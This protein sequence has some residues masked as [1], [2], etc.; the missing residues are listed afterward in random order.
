MS[1]ALAFMDLFLARFDSLPEGHNPKLFYW[2]SSE[3]RHGYWGETTCLSMGISSIGYSYQH[4][5]P[6]AWIQEFPA[7]WF[8]LDGS[9]L[10][11]CFSR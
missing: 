10:M 5:S 8:L 1:F 6:L 3:R 4:L 11:L 9:V 2:T 7:A